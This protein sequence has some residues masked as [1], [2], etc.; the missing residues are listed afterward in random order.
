MLNYGEYFG[1]LYTR[2]IMLTLYV[3]FPLALLMVVFAPEEK[4]QNRD[5]R[6]RYGNLFMSIRTTTRAQ[7]CY[8][9][10]FIIRRLLLIAVAFSMHAYSCQQVQVVMYFN[11]F[12]LIYVAQTWPFRSPYTNKMELGT[13]FF[14]ICVTFHLLTFTDWVPEKAD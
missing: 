2:L 8:F 3:L 6:N 14:V 11:I 1:L 13:E 5:F 12:V 10:L 7:R 4:L 9:L